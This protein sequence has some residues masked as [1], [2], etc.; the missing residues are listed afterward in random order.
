MYIACKQYMVKY[1]LSHF[2][3]IRRWLK[4]EKG[5]WARKNQR[6]S[7]SNSMPYGILSENSKVN[8]SHVRF[9]LLSR[10]YLVIYEILREVITVI[11][12]EVF[13]NLVQSETMLR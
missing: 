12:T 8:S 5:R 9:K 11:F 10:K 6:Y 2:T 3:K 4:G 13:R 1:F 7:P